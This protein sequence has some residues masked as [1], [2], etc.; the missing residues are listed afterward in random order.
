MRAGEPGI[1]LGDCQ[2]ATTQIAPER[3]TGVRGDEGEHDLAARLGFE[4]VGATDRRRRAA[5]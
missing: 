1:T 3:R 4:R 5:A 2:T